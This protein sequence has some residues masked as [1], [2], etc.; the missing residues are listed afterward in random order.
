M[1]G[2]WHNKKA[3]SADFLKDVVRLKKES[4]PENQRSEDANRRNDRK[5]SNVGTICFPRQPGKSVN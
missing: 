1:G 3:I 2:L 5:T 4:T